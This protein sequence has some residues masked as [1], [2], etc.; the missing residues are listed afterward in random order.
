VK[1]KILIIDGHPNENSFCAAIAD[2]YTR[3]AQSAEIE[4][5]VLS[6][7]NL[8]FDLNLRHGYRKIQ[9]LEPDL[10][11]A[12]KKIKWCEH[13]VVIYPIWWGSMPALLKGFLD[14][15]WLP[16]FGF[17]YHEGDPF[18]DRLLAG[19]SARVIVTSDA[20]ALYNLITYCNAPVIIMKKMILGFCGF[21][22][23]RTTVIGGVKNLSETKRAKL[24]NQ[25]SSLGRQ[26][27]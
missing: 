20:P 17:K 19:R 16:G 11:E 26:G 24:L 15:C 5:E 2:A 25:I 13:L 22:P 3:G 7:R 6:L 12:Q 8:N 14:R 4:V 1:N 27:N 9:E 18:W 10:V 23:V 21:K